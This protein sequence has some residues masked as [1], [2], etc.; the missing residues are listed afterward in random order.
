[1]R[2]YTATEIGTIL[3]ISSNKV[4]RLANNLNLKGEKGEKNEYGEW[5]KDKAVYS[6]KEVETFRYTEKGLEA[7]KIAIK[8]T[9]IIEEEDQL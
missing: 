9:E 4:G 1:L 2:T 3:G 5:F 7:I 6:N 8:T